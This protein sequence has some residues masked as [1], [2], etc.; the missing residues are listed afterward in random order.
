MHIYKTLTLLGLTGTLLL[1]ITGCSDGDDDSRETDGGTA[2][3]GAI[4][5]DSGNDDN[6]NNDTDN[7]GGNVDPEDEGAL[8]PDAGIAPA[9]PDTATSDP[10]AG[11]PDAAATTQSGAGDAAV[12]TTDAGPA[13]AVT[14]SDNG[15]ITAEAVV[16]FDEG[17]AAFTAAIEANPNVG[18]GAMLDHQANAAGL[19]SSVTIPPA[20]VFAFGNPNLGTPL[21]VENPLAAIDLPLRMLI[22]QDAEGGNF[23]SYDGPAYL[24]ARH[25]LETVDA[26]LMQAMGALAAFGSAAAGAAI[27][28]QSGD[29]TGIERGEG[30]KVTLS[31]NDA[32]TTLRQLTAAIEANPMLGIAASVDH[33]ANAAS[34]N[35]ELGFSTVVWFGNPAVGTP[36]IAQQPRIG[37]D[38]PLKMLVA[39]TDVGVLIAYNEPALL[40]E[41]HGV[42]GEEARITGMATALQGLADAAAEP[43]AAP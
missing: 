15:T 4:N 36:L 33:Q 3:A 24:R 31:N 37:L 20:S 8:A 18:L 38:L 13:M 40:A 23:V 42:T 21:M 29:A 7:T 32:A 19:A 10:D 17:A 39:E 11:D 2:D 6:G 5:E 27:E 16:A 22:W 41:K 9:Q 35:L 43:A 12:P 34:V 25:G 1:P 14:T 30:I 28:P 26:Q